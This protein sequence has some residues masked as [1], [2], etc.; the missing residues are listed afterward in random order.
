MPELPEVEI[1]A[2]I[3]AR[4]IAESVVTR[5]E[6]I[7]C[8]L[9]RA[10]R[11]QYLIPDEPDSLG[12]PDSPR[13]ERPALIIDP[14]ELTHALTGARAAPRCVSRVG[15]LMAL[16]WQTMDGSALTLFMRLGM[17]G[18][19]YAQAQRG[20]PGAGPR[21]GVKLTLEL[22]SESEPESK[23][24][25]RVLY[26]IN[27][28]MFGAVWALKSALL[29]HQAL[30]QL[31]SALAAAHRAQLKVELFSSGMGPDALELARDPER[32]TAHLRDYAKS[33]SGRRRSIKSAL[34]DQRLIAGVGNIYAAEGIFCASAHPLTP[35]GD[36]TDKQLFLIALGVKESME[37]TLMSADCGDELV[38]GSARGEASP[39]N[40]YGREGLGCVRCGA[41]LINLVISGR[42]TVYCPI[43]QP[44]SH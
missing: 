21:R 44:S 19:I 26:F 42:A 11:A 10:P 37:Y 43:C 18:Q 20:A 28:R 30:D 36:L 23:L 34:L 38:Y 8:K 4:A 12:S 3:A 7:P 13:Y 25:S 24:N 22:E 1:N 41:T 35:I 32:W 33:R 15:K 27:T 16:H 6:L 39:F 31:E 14:A 2:R 40:V 9:F 17:T 29:P 5:A